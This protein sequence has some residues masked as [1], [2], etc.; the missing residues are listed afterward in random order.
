MLT[1]GMIR[2]MGLILAARRC[3]VGTNSCT[4][5]TVSWLRAACRFREKR[6]KEEVHLQN[7]RS[8]GPSGIPQILEIL[9]Q[10]PSR[11]RQQKI[12]LQCNLPL[13][14]CLVQ[15]EV[16]LLPRQ[17]VRQPLKAVQA[18]LQARAEVPQLLVC[19]KQQD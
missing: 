14:E 12:H 17:L 2:L 19:R 1:S 11:V 16:V 8:R 15:G 7:N 5:H 18:Q 3:Q 9:G 4:R 13:N 6:P 10:V